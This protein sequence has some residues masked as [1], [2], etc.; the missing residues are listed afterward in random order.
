[1]FSFQVKFP[2][3]S[4]YSMVAKLERRVP[5]KYSLDTSKQHNS[6][7]SD[8]K[9]TLKHII[10]TMYLCYVRGTGLVLTGLTSSLDGVRQ[11]EPADFLFTSESSIHGH[12]GDGRPRRCQ[13]H[14]DVT[15]RDG[16]DKRCGGAE[17]AIACCDGAG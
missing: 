14:H 4:F 8:T 16:R 15:S 2:V 3:P 6:T 7:L 1:M 13:Y 5:I 17:T 10:V 9:R 11:C 12:Q